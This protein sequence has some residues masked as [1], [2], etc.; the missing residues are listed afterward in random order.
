MSPSFS[1]HKST[2]TCLADTICRP[3]RGL[4]LSS[5]V[6]APNSANNFSSQFRVPVGFS[7]QSALWFCIPPVFQAT[8]GV[9]ASFL[10][11]VA[12]IVSVSAEPQMIDANTRWIIA[13]VEYTQAI[14][15]RTM[16]KSPCQSVGQDKSSAVRQPSVTIRCSEASPYPATICVRRIDVFQ[17]PCGY[18]HTAAHTTILSLGQ[19]A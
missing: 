11:A 12:C 1:Q 6:S 14:G 3:E 9:V 8:R 18:W 4:R 13:T 2:D 16:D 19:A 15:N 10:L 5:C 7:F 17:Q